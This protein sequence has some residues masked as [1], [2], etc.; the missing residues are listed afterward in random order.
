MKK[1]LQNKSLLVVL[2]IQTILIVLNFT[3]FFTEGE[4][5]IFCLAGDGLKNYYTI[6]S[7]FLQGKGEF[8]MFHSMNYPFSEYIFFTDNSPSFAVP[9]KCDE[10]LMN[11]LRTETM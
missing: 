4:N 11:D 5:V 10:G 3:P 8:A 9:L 6:F 7:Y 1:F 2:L